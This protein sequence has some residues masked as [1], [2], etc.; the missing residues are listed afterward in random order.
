MNSCGS[1]SCQMTI[2]QCLETLE[3]MKHQ[4]EIILPYLPDD[5][6]EN[7]GIG[8]NLDG[9]FLED[10]SCP[11]DPDR[12]VTKGFTKIVAAKQN[13]DGS[14]TKMFALKREVPKLHVSPCDTTMTTRL[15]NADIF[16]QDQSMLCNASA[17]PQRDGTLTRLRTTIEN[18]MGCRLPQPPDEN[19]PI[20]E[21]DD[22]ENPP[23][24]KRT[25]ALFASIDDAEEFLMVT[26]NQI[27]TM[28]SKIAETLKNDALNCMKSPPK[29]KTAREYIVER[30]LAMLLDLELA[31]EGPINRLKE[32][33][34]IRFKTVIPELDT[35]VSNLVLFQNLENMNIKSISRHEAK[36]EAHIQ[37]AATGGVGGTVGP[38][39]SV[40]ATAPLDTTQQSPSQ[41]KASAQSG[42]NITVSETSNKEG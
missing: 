39:E 11:R 15:N 21:L 42:M 40:Y 16:P 10:S 38:N 26:I 35:A 12:D 30:C 4:M 41:Q 6:R 3:Q 27:V 29:D 24:A 23:P 19:D 33:W 25:F 22:M 31:M 2:E 18:K 14:F 8:A 20:G 37:A 1:P 17:R 36:I 9:G 34:I 13:A 7:L 28:F 5:V 32:E